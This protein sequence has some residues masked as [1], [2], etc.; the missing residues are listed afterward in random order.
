MMKSEDMKGCRCR[1]GAGACRPGP[2]RHGPALWALRV[3]VIFTFHLFTFSHVSFADPPTQEDVL[4]SIG[5]NV[6]ESDDSGR[7]LGALAA[8]AGGIVLLVVV[9]QRRGREAGPKT[10]HSHPKLMKEVLRTVPLKPAEVKQLKLL[11]HEYCARGGEAEGAKSPLTLV[12]CPS[13]LL[14]ATHARPDKVKPEV[15]AGLA[16]KLGAR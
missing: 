3:V 16:R 8:I 15:V 13:L 1:I 14:K 5:K 2:G 10:L 12:L 7:V 11:L 6:S 9:G 4:R